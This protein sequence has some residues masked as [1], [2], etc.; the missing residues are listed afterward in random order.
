LRLGMKLLQSSPVLLL[1]K[2]MV[3][4]VPISLFSFKISIL[5]FISIVIRS[6]GGFGFLSTF[7]SNRAEVNA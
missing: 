6:F 3:N 7:L 4:R 5:G 2:L 1:A